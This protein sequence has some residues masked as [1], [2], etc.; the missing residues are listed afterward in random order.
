M[1]ENLSK[2]AARDLPDLP[3]GLEGDRTTRLW[4][5][6]TLFLLAFTLVLCAA[7]LFD[8]RSLS[9]APV[10]HKPMKF[11]LSLAIHFATLAFLAQ[12]LDRTRRTGFTLTFFGYSAIA[13]M[14]FEQVYISIQA[15]RGRL[16]HFNLSSDLEM[17]LYGLMGV[18]AVI[19]VLTSLA[20]GV[21]IWRFGQKDQS[22]VRLGA[23]AGLILGSILTLVYAGYMSGSPGYS[24]YVGEPVT[25]AHIPFLGWSREVGDLRVAHFIATHMM[26][27]LPLVGL[28]A[29]RLQFNPRRTV[30]A[31]TILLAALSALAFAQAIAGQSVLPL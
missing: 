27:L 16:S 22:G 1:F 3:F 2:P 21:M 12:H 7:N 28:A 20:L 31:A 17:S 30:V 9:G 19:L 11:A 15:G 24:H 23:I 10:W 29:D 13:A 14:L 6:A 25:G 8:S 4:W 26:Q 5:T 18:G